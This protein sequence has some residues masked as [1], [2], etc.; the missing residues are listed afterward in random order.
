MTKPPAGRPADLVN[1]GLIAGQRIA[2]VELF[3]V[4]IEMAVRSQIPVI[5]RI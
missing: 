2:D 5:G 1:E 4:R 3:L